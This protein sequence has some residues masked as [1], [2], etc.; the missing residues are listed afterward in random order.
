M[1]RKSPRQGL[2]A[3]PRQPQ[4]QA[5]SEP[6]AQAP[7]SSRGPESLIVNLPGSLGSLSIFLIGSLSVQTTGS[8]L[9][10]LHRS[11]GCHEG[12]SQFDRNTCSCQCCFYISADRES[13][14]IRQCLAGKGTRL[15]F[16]S[17]TEPWKYMVPSSSLI[18]ISYTHR[19]VGNHLSCPSSALPTS[20]PKY[21]LDQPTSLIL[22]ATP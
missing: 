1:A 7:S 6:K 17:P 21:S 12:G 14:G 11:D 9:P 4:G 18:S 8:S 5:G 2:H 19:A 3:E 16:I 20:S 22:T 13:L 10:Y 15:G